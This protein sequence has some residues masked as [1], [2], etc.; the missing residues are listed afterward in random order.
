M[1]REEVNRD[2]KE[3]A[4]V[5]QSDADAKTKYKMISNIL[6]AKPHYFEVE[7]DPCKNCLFGEGTVYCREHCPYEAKTEQKPCDDIAEERYKDLCEY[8]GEAKDILESRK[9]FK[10]WL[11]RV[12]WHIH[13]A[14]ELYEKYEYKQ[15]P[16]DTISRADKKHIDSFKYWCETNEEKGTIT[17]P[18]FVC[19]EIIKILDKFSSVQPSRKGKWEYTKHYGKRYRVCPFCKAEKE[20]D[21]SSGWNFCQYCGADMRGAE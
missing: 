14:E 12:K 2:I 17:I 18:K 7:Q 11:E 20:D 10:A 5:L 9:E 1:T 8:F 19:D 13:K 15:E 16:R 3:I 21:L 4:E 6:S